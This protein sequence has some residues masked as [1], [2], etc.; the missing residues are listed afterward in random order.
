MFNTRRK[1]RVCGQEFVITNPRQHDCNKEIKKTCEIC[2]REFTGKCS[3][4]DRSTTCSKECSQQL[5]AKRRK[6]SYQSQ[7]KICE[8]CGLEFHPSSNTQKVCEREHE[9]TC[10]VCGKKFKL[11][12][13]SFKGLTDL[14]QTCSDECYRQLFKGNNPF[15]DEASLLKYKATMKE[16]YGV[17]HPMHSDAIKS[18]IAATYL[19]RTG[20]DHPSHNPNTLKGKKLFNSSLEKK[21]S[22]VLTNSGIE[23]ETQK[24]ISKNNIY[25]KF[26]FFLPHYSMLIDVDGEYYHGYLD[27]SNGEQVSEDRDQIRTYLVG[28]N[29]IYNVIVESNFN[30]EVTD[31]LDQLKNIDSSTFDYDEYMFNWCRNIE[32]PYPV[33]TEERLV[34]DFKHLCTYDCVGYNSHAKLGMSTIRHFHK[35]IYDARVGTSV[36][37]KEAWSNDDILRKV[38]KNRMIY[39][40]D[41]DPSKIL[42]GFYISK[43]VPKVSV[44]NPVLARYLTLKY[45]S[46]FNSVVDPFSGFSGRLLGVASCNKH[47]IGYDLNSVAVAESNRIIQFHNLDAAVEYY[48]ILDEDVN[49]QAECL[50]TCP[51]YSTKEKYSTETEFKTCDEWIHVVL[52]KF[53]CKRYIFVVG[54]TTD[55]KE[56]IAEEL[57]TKS[58]FTDVHEF[59]LVIDKE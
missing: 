24:L 23:F 42:S 49:K 29:Q 50:L 4:N 13:K 58:Y 54:N 16:R 26:D 45:L 55:F 3:L 15:A 47:Y 6:E 36:S 2:G 1:C 56:N 12:Y 32:F 14:R 22:N 19:D 10:K 33:Y 25:H 59:V 5:A 52:N 8:L 48:N 43:I 17:E 51:P 57:V 20:F 11:N 30:Q 28:P 39:Q 40:N 7:T 27:D 38:I 31:L 35:S 21:L 18:R 9:G 34:K 37:L 46:G 44:F 53:D 41:I